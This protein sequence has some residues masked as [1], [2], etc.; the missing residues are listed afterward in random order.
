MNME[1]MKN[2]NVQV[3]ALEVEPT[4]SSV[5]DMQLLPVDRVSEAALLRLL[6]EK[7]CRL[8][9]AEVGSY[10]WREVQ[11]KITAEKSDIHI[12]HNLWSE[13]CGQLFR[14]TKLVEIG[15]SNSTQHR[16]DLIFTDPANI[17]DAERTSFIT[18]RVIGLAMERL[19]ENG[20]APDEV[21]QS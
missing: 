8:Q 3:T 7:N 16:P 17:V 1:V 15:K 11:A 13:A 14:I 6:E 18:P 12:D 20:A 19:G 9:H 2:A 10:Y 21:D 5:S 4:F